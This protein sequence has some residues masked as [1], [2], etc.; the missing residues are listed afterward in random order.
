[1][2]GMG[3]T[4]HLSDFKLVLQRPKEVLAGTVCHY[5]IMPL[6]AFA[7]TKVF[8][9]S[10]DLAVGM[11]LLGSCPSGTASNVMSFLAKGDVPL[12]VSVTTVSTLL[13]PV[14]MPFLVWA[15]AGEYVNVSFVSMAL[16]V[17]KVIL[18]PLVLG[19]LVHKAVGEKF[20]AQIQKVLVLLSAFAVLSILGGVVAVN[21]AKIV[22]L[23]AFVVVLVIFISVLTAPKKEDAKK[24]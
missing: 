24:E 16:T 1:M 11:V 6:V 4:L 12:A 13:A 14:M 5:T 10:P 9:L 3:M 23:G 22:A 2:F 15:L 20:L 18:V 7:L 17:M 8:H 21:G 19:L